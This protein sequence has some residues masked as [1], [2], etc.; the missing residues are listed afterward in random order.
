MNMALR[1]ETSTD[2]EE[3]LKKHTISCP[4]G[5]LTR[6]QCEMNR[7][8]PTPADH[9]KI[10]PGRHM[11]SAKASAVVFRPGA[12]EKCTQ[13]KENQTP[14]IGVDM[15]AKKCTECGEEKRI[16][17]RGLCGKCYWRLPDVKEKANARSW[18]K[19]A[20]KKLAA[21]G[22]QQ[23]VTPLEQSSAAGG[24]AFA[25]KAGGSRLAY[26]ANRLF[27]MSGSARQ[28]RGTCGGPG[29]KSGSAGPVSASGRCRPHMHQ[30]RRQR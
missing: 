7:G 29:Q 13:W 26:P 8:R 27:R 6:K 17:G 11:S 20:A 22:S 15:A 23:A 1:F 30:L 18:A 14:E 25:A 2:A 19:R 5:R 3:W 16:I 24:G 12:C 21:S 9:F 4:L 10:V 28:N